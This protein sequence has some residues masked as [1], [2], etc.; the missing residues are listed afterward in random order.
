MSDLSAKQRDFTYCVML[1]IKYAYS[2]GYE[3]T[4]GDAYRDPRVFGEFKGT[5]EGSYS[6]KNSTHKLRLAIDLNLFVGGVYITDGN[7]PAYQDIG[8]FWKSTH[9]DARWGHDFPGDANHFSFEMW[10]AK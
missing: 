3:M 7:H 4:L 2:K 10:G 1:L 8:K 5:K 6:A 9:V